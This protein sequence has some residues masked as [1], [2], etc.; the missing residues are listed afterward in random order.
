MAMVV[1][2]GFM[3][4][5]AGILQGVSGFGSGILIMMVLPSI[6]PLNQAAG[7]SGAICLV[8]CILMSWR[9]RK[10]V[11]WEKVLGPAALYMVVSGGSIYFSTMVNQELMK[12]VFG[13]F[14]ILLSVYYLFFN[15]GGSSH[16]SM[17]VKAL[18]IAVSGACDGL[19]GIGGPLMVIY[20]LSQ[21]DSK[22]EYLGTIQTL[23]CINLICNS[24]FRVYNGIL[25]PEHVPYIAMGSLCIL[26]GFLVAG[27]IVDKLDGEKLKKITY[28]VIGI[29]GL[30]NIIG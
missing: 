4:L 2:V 25:G 9:Y 22:E 8:L 7:V 14:L 1:F 30:L 28:V 27:R 29:S 5:C 11:H 10:H 16:L 17:P 18:F 3:T 13:V 20:Y 26:G 21:T 12:K 15:K 23:F 6:F 19:F 24:A